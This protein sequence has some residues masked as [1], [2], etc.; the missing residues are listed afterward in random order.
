MHP[1]K[2]NPHCGHGD[3]LANPSAG[4]VALYVVGGLTAVGLAGV[5]AVV[6]LGRKGVD[7]VQK[8]QSQMVA[9]QAKLLDSMRAGKA[10]AMTGGQ[11]PLPKGF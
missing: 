7:A 9:D 10:A 5:A 8:Q 2:M 4:T 3:S 6:Y 11:L 1:F